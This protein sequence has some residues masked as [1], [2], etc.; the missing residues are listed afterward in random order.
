LLRFCGVGAQC[1]QLGSPR[2]LALAD[3]VTTFALARPD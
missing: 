1:D 3:S 2:T